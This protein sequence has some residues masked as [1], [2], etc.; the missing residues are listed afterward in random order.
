MQDPVPQPERWHIRLAAEVA[1]ALRTD[2]TAGLTA[3]EAA[4]RLA[5]TG[6]NLLVPPVRTPVWKQFLKQFNDLM[7]WVLLAAVAIS[8]LEGQL[9][10]ALAITVI[11][12]LNGVLGFLQEYRAERA[13]EA[14]E[15]MAA[16]TAAVIRDGV[17][18]EVA[19]SQLVPGDIV[20]L[21][22]GDKV[23]ADGR[24]LEAAAL[25]VEEASLTGESLPSAKT[26]DALTEEELPL[27]D[28]TNMLFAGTSVA[29]GRA[30]YVVTETG[31]A[32]EMGRIADLLGQQHEDPTPL[33]KE[34]NSVGKI[35]A[36]G[37]LA[38]AA[39]VFAVDAWQ[40]W[41]STG[42]LPLVAALALPLFR[43]KLTV[44]LLIAISLAVAAIPEGLPAIVTVAL[45]LGVRRMAERNAI[46]RRLHAVE[47]LGATTFICTDKTGTLTRN[48]M[49]VRHLVVGED[50][51]VVGS[52]WTL[53]PTGAAPRREDLEAMLSAAAS[54]NDARFTA[55]GVLVGDPT[56]TALIVAADRLSEERVRPRRVGEVP[57]DSARKRMTT[58]HAID[59]GRVTCTK[60]A[61]D[62]VLHLC[63][64][65]VLRGETVPMTAELRER[66][67]QVNESLAADGYR[68]LA[69]AARRLEPSEPDG[70]EELERDMAY[71]GIVAMVDPP[72]AEVPQAVAQ[73]HR[74]GISVAM[75]TGDHALTAVAIGREIGLLTD[76][77]HERVVSGVELERMS[78]EELDA[79]VDDIRIYARVDPE[80]KL[81]IVAALKRRGHVVAMTGDGV[82]DAPALKRADIGVAMG[83][84]GTDVARE[85]ADMV[86]A[87]DDFATIVAAIRRGRGVFDNLR[88][89][90]LFLLS[91]NISEVSIVFLT[92]L[93]SATPALLPLQLLW[94]NLV[95]DGL[96]ALALGVDPESRGIMERPPRGA[97]DSVLTPRRRAQVV[98]Q[99]AAITLAGLSMYLWT[100]TFMPGHDQAR[101]QTMLFTAMVLAQLLHAFDFRSDTSTVFSRNSLRNGWLIAALVGSMSLHMLVVYVPAL[102]R[103]FSTRALSLSDW[104]WV[105]AAALIPVVIIDIAKVASARFGRTA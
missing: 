96:P 76:P 27:G 83:R 24:L 95:T 104:G 51:S 49:T 71:L 102:Q 87:D 60:G 42:H 57:F 80:H 52:D 73:C 50:G 33:E 18:T 6:E 66:L 69:V 64:S 10:D 17:E 23:P 105:L 30:R 68:T 22:S 74:A 19:A 65:A 93:F 38:I 36:I 21:E 72:R 2:A 99:G 13:M 67:L 26:S 40:A 41:A 59:G 100:S 89:S 86:L 7:I 101:A 56:E 61:A 53:E 9:V 103:V 85:A 54:C 25:R 47:T 55:D 35:I 14:L 92:S 58:I 48:E 8:A 75:V 15:E 43:E 44:S 12:L 81:R 82:N 98:W 16:P 39:L 90:I 79:A 62:V 4:A 31:Q 1:S 88:K 3:G 70:G 94:I 32:T 11:L 77:S 63:S 5:A 97:S 91:C 20:L 29:V 28:R 78:D 45:S 34:L 37:V 46:V 84:V